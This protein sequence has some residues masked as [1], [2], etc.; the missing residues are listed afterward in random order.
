MWQVGDKLGRFRLD[1]EIGQGSHGVVFVAT[2]TALD[3]AVAVKILHPWLTQDTAVRDRFKR[4]LLLARRV[5]HP[6]VCRLFDLHEEGEAFFITMD[7]VEGQTLLTILKNEG[8]IQP[9]R[10]TKIMRGVCQALC[11]AHNAGVIHRDLKP[12]NII[13]R[14][15]DNPMILD[16]GT[17]TAGD[18]SRVTRPGTA[19][20]SMRF[21]APE[22]FTGVSPSIRTDIYS[23]G[24]VAYVTLA[25]KLPYNAAAGALEML[26]M[27]RHQPP[28]RLDVAQPD[29]P[30]LLA[31]VVARAMEKDPEAR[32]SS[33]LAFD[34]A[35]AEVER[36]LE[37]PPA[38]S[39]STG[40]FAR[41]A[42]AGVIRD[43]IAP[44]AGDAGTLAAAAITAPPTAQ[45]AVTAVNP[46]LQGLV[47]GALLSEGSDSSPGIDGI[48]SVAPADAE[49]N[50][51]HVETD[52]SH[53]SVAAFERGDAAV[54]S[55]PDATDDDGP[56]ASSEAPSGNAS[57]LTGPAAD[58]GL[59]DDERAAV[60]GSG[61]GVAARDKRLLVA[62]G[63]VLVGAAAAI[64]AL[65]GGD[66]ASAGPPEVTATADA[67]SV[68]AAAAVDAGAAA[69]EAARTVDPV[70]AAVLE[71]DEA[72]AEGDPAVS[73][74]EAKPRRGKDPRLDRVYDDIRATRLSMQKRGL[75]PG[76]V[77]EVEEL[78]LKARR[79]RD[80]RWVAQARAL[81]DKQAVDRA[82]VLAKLQRFNSKY[83]K[84]K[85]P[86]VAGKVEPLAR[87]AAMSFS[88][89]QF[90]QANQ[91]LNR[92]FL[93]LGRKAK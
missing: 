24:V 51:F 54:T 66:A 46:R 20:G 92:A 71:I 69:D 4:E 48:P 45:A 52:A 38:T 33:A 77:P 89:G 87:E 29:V 90:E 9:L 80:E 27:I 3:S 88:A 76:D 78:L 35:L 58:E 14:T 26:E 79:Q 37:A 84:S 72:D 12:A 44:A 83:D 7:Y 86:D 50:G 2:D 10:A 13:V 70:E 17:A 31:D 49:R 19:V 23:L 91:K 63:V 30:P 16:F 34:E 39:A 43:A 64:F 60:A 75:I 82:F 18:V 47:L 22:I 65:S 68:P 25:G 74:R 57:S 67:P 85:R 59:D 36:K 28:Q 41:W 55:A 40:D 62:A 1:R 61:I 56:V 8:R 42:P 21:I 11:A 93:L 53:A 81:A 6:G 32:F 15:G 5:A 73:T